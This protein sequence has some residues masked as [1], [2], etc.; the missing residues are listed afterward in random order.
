[1][2]PAARLQ[3]AIE[4]SD[5]VEQSAAPADATVRAALR[6]RRYVGAKD[7]RE[8][9]ELVFDAARRRV[10]LDWRIAR[11]GGA[12]SARLRLLALAAVE[13]GQGVAAVEAL[14]D[15]G[16]YAPAPLGDG[17]RAL[18]AAMA[19][20]VARDD[21]DMPPWAQ[22]GVPEWLAPSLIRRFGD[23]LAAEMA[24][25]AEPAPLDLRVDARRATRAAVLAELRSFGLDAEPTP[26]SPVGIR[27]RG[28]P[29]LS[30]H[31][32]WREGVIEVQDE[33]AQLVALLV[34]APAARCVVDFCAGAGGKTLA[35]ATLIPAG[36]R[37]IA[38]DSDARRLAR[39]GP[40]LARAGIEGVETELL[41]GP[42]DPWPRA[43][44]GI[45][46]RVLLDVPCSGTGTW[47]RSPDLRRTLTAERLR[48]YR[49]QQAAILD[50]AAP[51]PALGGRLVYASCS[52]LPEENE[53]QVEAFLA[54]APAF[55]PLDMARVWQETIGT[56]PPA[57][58]D[59]PWLQL[60]P[61][62]HG[63]DGFFIAVLERGPD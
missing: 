33:G 38:C 13:R 35:L 53:D 46:D 3:A 59:G 9:L 30:R 47:R 29:L 24:A 54:R 26:L 60:T 50:H 14:C 51:L 45:A 27:V 8:I 57:G 2:T 22:A 18:L 39:L 25:L 17:E 32:A 37:L 4:L 48:H 52:L 11:H 1:M 61:H 31:P 6:R 42:A 7:R 19:G 43:N 20:S 10:R 16:R 44:A 21:A 55:R 34:G 58:A 62:R 23:A 28:R 49:D 56:A 36:A 5:A 15:G 12:A 40:R 41:A 63:T